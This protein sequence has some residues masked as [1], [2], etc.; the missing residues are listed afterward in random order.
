MKCLDLASL[1][2]G[3]ALA[4]EN[5]LPKMDRKILVPFRDAMKSGRSLVS[6]LYLNVAPK[7]WQESIQ[8]LSISAAFMGY[9]D[10][11]LMLDDM[12]GGTIYCNEC[13]HKIDMTTKYSN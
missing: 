11:S 8:F 3:L 5:K 2:L 9:G 1:L 7:S 4:P 10:I 12:S 6:E 13:E